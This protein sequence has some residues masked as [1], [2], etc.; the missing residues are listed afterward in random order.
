MQNQYHHRHYAG[1]LKQFLPILLVLVVV[2]M[3]PASSFARD[4]VIPYIPREISTFPAQMVSYCNDQENRPLCDKIKKDYLPVLTEKDIQTLRDIWGKAPKQAVTRKRVLK[5]EK[6]DTDYINSDPVYAAAIDKSGTLEERVIEGMTD[7]VIT[8]A[9][10]EAALYIQDELNNQL[11]REGSEKRDYFK[12]TCIAV[13]AAMDTSMS[14]HGMGS[15]LRMAIRR[16]LENIPDK[17]LEK[18]IE[19]SAK[20]PAARLDKAE[21]LTAARIVLA[22]Y[23]ESRNGR[24]PIELISG[25]SEIRKF[26]CERD[27]GYCTEL[28][29]TMRIASYIVRSLDQTNGDY[30]FP[31][32]D[33]PAATELQR[34]K[35]IGAYFAFEEF[36]AEINKNLS[37]QSKLEIKQTSVKMVQ[38]YLG[39]AGLEAKLDRVRRIINSIHQPI[40]VD[41]GTYNYDPR[42]NIYEKMMALD[43]AFDLLEEAAAATFDLREALGI[44]VSADESSSKKDL[45][46]ERMEEVR[47]IFDVARQ[48]LKGDEAALMVA[49][50]SMDSHL[51][52]KIIPKEV[53]SYIPVFT[54]IANANSSRE[55]SNILEAASV[56]VGS[57]RQ[58]KTRRLTT[59]NAFVGADIWGKEVYETDTSKEEY[60]YS[61]ALF[62]P[63]GIH[64]TK[65]LRRKPQWIGDEFLH[66][67]GGF[68]SLIDLGPMVNT[69]EQADIE[70]Q[71][72]IGFKQLLSPGVFL[73]MGLWR[74]LTLGGGWSITPEIVRTKTEG[75]VSAH[76]WQIFLALD[77]TLM[78]L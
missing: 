60:S 63:V 71:P 11:C 67:F 59:L 72:N 41:D 29:S 35:L 62:A 49:A 23:R 8:R 73:T 68:V 33:A 52:N 44:F 56:Q 24:M 26:E 4:L 54:E 37:P 21:A 36:E 1:R 66:N 27:G 32:E 46:Y 58:K 3:E 22:G 70:S 30:S 38:K 15:Y 77:L 57:Y 75:D 78:P 47:Y 13:N 17:I 7:F 43:S 6:M 5:L 74:S 20:E 53:N 18:E 42:L 19:F 25:I 40:K 45:F 2:T 28:L 39:F 12:S 10:A 34:Y 55:V 9:K 50:M 14:L 61:R 31:Q 51:A 16:D 76:R 48:L 64:I 69:R 65:P